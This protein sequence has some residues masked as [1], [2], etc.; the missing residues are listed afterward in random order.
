M[1]DQRRAWDQA[2]AHYQQAIAEPRSLVHY[3]P[4][5][6]AEAEL[7]LLGDVRGL[8]ILE[9]GCGGGQCAVA[10][11]QQGAQVTGVDVSAAQL[12]YAQE[13]AAA[14]GVAVTFVAASAANLVGFADGAWDLVFAVYALPY[15]TPL[16]QCLAECW[17]VLRPGGR[18]VFSLDHPVRDCFFDAQEQEL[19]LY[20]VHDYFD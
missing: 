14:A 2:A 11:A 17:R 19:V 5:V 3:G 16:E 13:R 4:W 10:F 20:P 1:I 12:H 8:A 7:Q 15:V 18:L 9:L 6:P